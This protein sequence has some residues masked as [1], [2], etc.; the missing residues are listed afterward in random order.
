MSLRE[1]GQ[2]AG[3]SYTTVSRI[4]HGNIDPTIRMLGR[5]LDACGHLLRLDAVPAG[6]ATT[7]ALADLADATTRSPAGER[8]DFT[9]L[10]SF[11]DYLALHPEA[12][13]RAITAAP[14]T[15]SRLMRALLAG[16]AE[17]L[18]DDHGLARPG[19]TWTA[20]KIKPEWSPATPRMRN[21]LRDRA[22]RQLLDRGLV[23]DEESL[24]RD[25]ETV[26][27]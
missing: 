1:V 27:V 6:T 18:A 5:I 12:V 21:R 20:P 15:D 17:K 2:L 13:H 10:R 11:L 7:P 4:E 19:W 26:G 9:R 8:P 3:V 24:F 22:P 16:I 23:V 25:R 14:R